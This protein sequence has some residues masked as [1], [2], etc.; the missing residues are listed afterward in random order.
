MFTA[1]HTAYSMVSVL[2]PAWKLAVKCPSLTPEIEMFTKFSGSSVCVS[3]F[4]QETAKKIEMAPIRS[5]KAGRFLKYPPP[6]GFFNRFHTVMCFGL[7]CK[8]KF[9]F[10]SKNTPPLYKSLCK[11]RSAFMFAAVVPGQIRTADRLLPVQTDHQWSVRVWCWRCQVWK[12]GHCCPL[13]LLPC[14]M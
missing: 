5:D 3:P 2:F 9:L 6:G 14:R 1:R 4:S 10:H 7:L 13:C 11:C 8:D 12:H